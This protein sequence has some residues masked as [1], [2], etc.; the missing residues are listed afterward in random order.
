MAQVENLKNRLISD[1]KINIKNPHT[2]R[3]LIYGLL[4]S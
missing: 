1:E 4:I 3:D 2:Q